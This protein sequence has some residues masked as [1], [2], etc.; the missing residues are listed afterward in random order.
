MMEFIQKLLNADIQEIMDY[1]NTKEDINELKEEIKQLTDEIFEKDLINQYTNIGIHRDDIEI[2]ING[3]DIRKYGSQGQQR[4]ATLS[5]KLSESVFL[6]KM[7]QEK[8]VIILDDVLSELDKKRQNQLLKILKNYQTIITATSVDDI[9]E[10]N[11]IK[12]I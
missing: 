7:T 11:E 6:E 5:L 8:P 4:T 2:K 12:I 3:T 9:D 1:I 10:F